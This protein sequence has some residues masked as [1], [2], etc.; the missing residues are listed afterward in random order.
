MELTIDQ[1]AQRVAMTARN[2]R[3]WQTLGL[4]PPPERRGRVG[5]YSGEHVALI[6]RVKQLRTQGLSLDF[7]RK[8]IERSG[9]SENDVRNLA[10]QVLSPFAAS[11]PANMPRAEVAERLGDS[12]QQALARLRLVS[13]VDDETV[14]V[15]D[16]TMLTE[17][18]AM[19]ATGMSL[20]RLVEMLVEVDRHQHAIADLVLQTYVN[21]VWNPFVKSGFTTPGWADVAENA[22]RT[23]PLAMTLLSRMMQTALDDVAARI[24]VAQSDTARKSPDADAPGQA[25]SA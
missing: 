6:E 24:M 8:L 4:I 22:T 23:R 17:I 3:E 2:I 14:A 19:V 5:L 18:E 10:T 13:D 7:I 16:L 12:A 9:E 21:D 20:D 1:L 11:L 25:S 15:R